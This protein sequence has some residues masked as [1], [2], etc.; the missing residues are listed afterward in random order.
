[1]TLRNGAGTGGS[2]VRVAVADATL[3]IEDGV[4]QANAGVAVGVISPE[5]PT[6]STTIVR[7]TFD[8]NGRAIES[9]VRKLALDE[10]VIR[11]HVDPVSFVVQAGGSNRVDVE[12]S[13]ISDNAT[14]ALAGG[15]GA[16]TITDSTIRDNG[17][18]GHSVGGV[19][20]AGRLRLERT[21]V[22]GNVGVGV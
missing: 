21:T 1:M 14:G 3:L 5:R 17:S 16:M 4:I 7:T 13:E 11:N 9:V 18:D 19:I 2:A 8:G 10:V 6:G 12:R 15:S 20:A 22:N